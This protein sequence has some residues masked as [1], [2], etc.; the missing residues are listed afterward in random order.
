MTPFTLIRFPTKTSTIF[1]DEKKS[2]KYES[3]RSGSLKKKMA[4]INKKYK[5]IKITIMLKN[6]ANPQN[7]MFHKSFKEIAIVKK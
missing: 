7:K 1:N 3:A 5:D 4:T 2:I 6:Q